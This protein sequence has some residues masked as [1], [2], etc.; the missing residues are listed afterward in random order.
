MVS[1]DEVINA[2]KGVLDPE[3]GID[4]VSLEM[5]RDVRVEGNSVTVVIALTTDACPLGNRIRDDAQDAVKQ[6]EGVGS[7]DIQ[8]SVMNEEERNKLM[9]K[10]KS[11]GKTTQLPSKLP[12]K[13]IKNII[14]VL[15]GKGGVGKSSIA[16]M[17]AVELSRRGHKVG[18]LDADITGPSI[19]KIFGEL[20]A[21]FVE[22]G[23]IV[24]SASK[25]GI[26]VMSM[27]LLTGE[28]EAPIIWRGPLVSSAIRQ[29]YADVEW[30]ELDYLV[31]DLP[32]GT[33]DAQLTV[34]QL[35]PV[36]GAIIVTSPQ[37]LAGLIVSKAVHM[38][39]M[40][41]VPILGIIENMSYVKCPRC[42]EVIHLFG[43]SKG[44]L[45][46]EKIN[47]KFLGLLPID[48]ALSKACDEGKIEEYSNPDF[49]EIVNK[50]VG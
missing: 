49:K 48:S 37:D 25:G 34:M 22:E 4:I 11:K 20:A 23:K 16:A 14:A 32:P 17:L 28:E 41:T 2:L 13:G 5:V 44:K 43:E 35:L 50:I 38:T 15:S 1:K 36:D 6:L 39:K 27:N 24:P 26:K 42:G 18:V 47:T 46:A 9:E 33:S 3:L 30:G 45:L 40:M 12:K 31:L 29:F 19:P 21:P 10:L 7:V 8:L